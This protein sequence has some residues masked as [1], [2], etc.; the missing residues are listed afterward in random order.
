[1]RTL[2]VDLADRSYPIYIGEGLLDD[3]R[4]FE[5]HI[6]GRQVAI[7]TNE[8]IAP[9]YLDRLQKTLVGYKVTTVV[10]PDG[11]AYKQW[12]TLQLIF[13]GLLTARH[14]RKTTLIALG[15][16]VIGDM[17]G[18]AA[19]CY[20][21]GVDF[22]QVP[23]TLLSQVDS[24]VGGKTGINHPLGKN[25]VGAFYQP[26]AVVIDTATLKTLPPREL[27]AGLAE[28]IKYGFICDEPFLTWLEAH[29]DDLLALETIALTEAIERSC[30]AK[31]RVVGADEKETGVRA[32]LNLG[33]T[34]GHAI[35]THM[36][37]GVWL[38]GEAVGAG[39]VMALEMSHRLGWLT[40][41]EL[42]RGIRLLAAAKLPV[43]PPQEMNAE[44]FLEHMAVDKKVLDGRLRLVLLQGLGGAVVTAEFPREILEETLRADYQALVGQAG[45]H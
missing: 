14:D 15:G 39:T 19:A 21:R 11:E 22:I 37:Y 2:N 29:M 16:G 24:S 25:M 23:T 41:A 45:E 7:V 27:S 31:A 20:Q 13:D 1:M 28:V 3:L 38:H 44:H 9:L 36:G 32:T 35:E 43:V 42:D 26:Q 18:F 17:T 34:F 10:L 6:R 33:H 12:E 40:K 5:P 4:Y 8:T 30:A